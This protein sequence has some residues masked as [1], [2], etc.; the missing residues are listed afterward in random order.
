MFPFPQKLTFLV[1]FFHFRS[2]WS[3]LGHILGPFW[4][5]F[6]FILVRFESILAIF[7]RL[8]WSKWTFFT[9]MGLVFNELFFQRNEQIQ[10]PF[11]GNILL[12][13]W[14]KYWQN[15]WWESFSLKISPQCSCAGFL[16]WIHIS[17]IQKNTSFFVIHSKW[18]FPSSLR[19]KRGH[20]YNKSP[21]HHYHK[22]PVSLFCRKE[23]ISSQCK[24]GWWCWFIFLLLFLH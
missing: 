13:V 23:K 3:H 18:I 17:C 1:F 24:N 15:I 20:R 2:L 10:F 6:W 12:S 14:Y 9:Q 5:D 16:A 7:V 22:R 11:C 4:C 21:K 8:F 19:K